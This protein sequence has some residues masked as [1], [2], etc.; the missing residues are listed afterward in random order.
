MAFF[1]SL[2]TD[3]VLINRDDPTQLLAAYSRHGFDLDGFYWPS[4]AHYFEGMKFADAD[5]QAKIREARHPRD[6]RK[7]ARRNFWKVRKDWKKIQRVIM[8]RGTYAKCRTHPEVA[9]ALLAT[10]D[11]ELVEHSLYD[12]YW[13]CGRDLRG[14]NYYG[15]MLMDVRNRLRDEAAAAQSE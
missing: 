9:Q 10:G 11:R 8:T 1:N 2:P 7:L 6:A 5:L 14:Y 3:A 13:G 12:N 4:V 15:K